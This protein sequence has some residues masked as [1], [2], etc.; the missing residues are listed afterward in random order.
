MG[1]FAIRVLALAIGTAA[2]VAVP[3]VTPAEAATIHG[4][5]FKKHKNRVQYGPV[6]VRPGLAV[7]RGWLRRHRIR[8][9]RSAR[10]SPE[11]SIARSGRLRTRTIPIEKFQG[12]DSGWR[13]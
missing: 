2:L 12:S 6:S 9:V 4:K 13:T 7:G 8:R 11:V 1:E 3:T 5:H 10:A